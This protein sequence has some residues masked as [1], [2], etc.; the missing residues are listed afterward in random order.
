MAGFTV[1]ARPPILEEALEKA[2][3]GHDGAQVGPEEPFRLLRPVAPVFE[4]EAVQQ[5]P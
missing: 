3:V 2:Q 1:C 5:L 4:D